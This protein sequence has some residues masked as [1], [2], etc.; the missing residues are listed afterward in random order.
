[1]A[2]IC[3]S[4]NGL[5]RWWSAQPPA[6]LLV[7]TADGV[8]RLEETA[9]SRPWQIVS[10]ALAGLHIS[11]L[12]R[13]PR[14]GVL[15]AGVH[16]EGL[17]RSFDDGRTWGSAMTGLRHGHIFCLASVEERA[18]AAVYAGAEPAYLY[19]SRD[20]GGTWEELPALRR[21]HG[22]DEW[23][24]PAPPHLAHVKHVAFDPRDCRRM[25]VCIEQG[26]LLRSDDGGESFRV[27]QFQDRTFRRSND[28]HRIVFNPR[29][30]TEISLVSG[31]G[32][33]RSH[34]EGETWERLTTPAMR[35]GYPDGCCYSPEE[36]RVLFVA[37]S[38]STPDE[39]RRTG[40]AAGALACSRDDGCNWA[41]VRGGLPRRIDGNIEAL[42]LVVWPG[43]FGFFAGTTDGDIF[44]SRDK[45]RN[46]TR[47]AAG[48]PP[49][50][51]CVH[52][53][54]LAHGRARAEQ[55]RMA[56]LQ[57]MRF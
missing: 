24:F 7:A 19:R 42:S 26:A 25:F 54:N 12:L 57:A 34:D 9:A 17:Y 43:A 48:L 37:G 41:A 55:V 13:E 40:N 11:S 44:C 53:R 39:W 4:P 29:R 46:W 56:S 31:E 36:H 6:A 20:L 8:V 33:S 14:S 35:I 47:I 21:V 49:V 28:P 3:L 27:L 50:S 16:G 18:G 23:S 52:Y 32:L 10:C 45:G 51:K 22:H 15:F 5:E 1:V 30:P 2:S 38:G